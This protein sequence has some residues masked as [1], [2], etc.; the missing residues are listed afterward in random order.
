MDTIIFTA[1]FIKLIGISL[2]LGDLLF[3]KEL[4][5]VVISEETAVCKK[6]RTELYYA[7][8]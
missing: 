6:I 8:V 7:D 1:C 3:D 4:I 2:C 5:S